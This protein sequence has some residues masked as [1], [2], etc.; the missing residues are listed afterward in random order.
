M[1][2]KEVDGQVGSYCS[3]K[4]AVDEAIIYMEHAAGYIFCDWFVSKVEVSKN[5]MAVP[6]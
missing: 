5:F 2:P 6:D 3:I 1:K 4:L